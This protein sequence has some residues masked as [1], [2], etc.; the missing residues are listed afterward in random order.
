MGVEIERKFLVVNQDWKTQTEGS[1][2]RQG[3]ISGEPGRIVRVRIEA[4]Q[5]SLTIKG[6]A[7]GIRC[8][9]WE[10]PIPL[11]DAEVLLAQVCVQPLIEKLRY[12]IAQDDVVWEIDEF[13]GANAGLVVAE[14]ELTSEDQPFARPSWL[15]AEVSHERRYANAN[16]QKHPYQAWTV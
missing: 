12:R 4:Q 7:T 8:G 16:L 14:V 15:G 3:Y 5:A 1:L 10:Y 6:L 11:A 2:L 9:E 13:F